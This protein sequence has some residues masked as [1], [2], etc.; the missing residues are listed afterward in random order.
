MLSASR[1]PRFVVR[2]RAEE[3]TALAL[4]D[5]FFLLLLLTDSRFV[6]Y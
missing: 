5:L 1:V 6:S 3:C 2:R 4:A